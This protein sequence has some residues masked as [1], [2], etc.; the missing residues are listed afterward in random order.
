MPFLKKIVLQR[1]EEGA[2]G[3]ESKEAILEL[4]KVEW[5]NIQVK[6]EEMTNEEQISLIQHF[7]TV[8]EE[9]NMGD[10]LFGEQANYDDFAQAVDGLEAESQEKLGI[11][12]KEVIEL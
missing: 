1:S 10:A 3:T 7:N 5:G 4:V 9:V 6:F 12:A 11:T 2:G 8:D